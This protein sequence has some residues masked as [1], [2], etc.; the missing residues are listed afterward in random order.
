MGEQR[1]GGDVH[2]GS[3]EPAAKGV[4]IDESLLYLAQVFRRPQTL[5]GHDL[6]IRGDGIH[7]D[8]TGPPRFPVDQYRAGTTQAQT[9]AELA[10]GQLQ[11]IP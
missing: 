10:P 9:T 5:D 11:I 3:A 8:H 4:V 1:S 2:A 6:L 7:L